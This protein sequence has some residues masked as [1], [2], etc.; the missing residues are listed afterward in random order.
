MMRWREPSG[1]LLSSG[2]SPDPAPTSP[3][4]IPAATA[5]LIAG[6]GPVGS[7]LAV[8]L[9]LRGID[10]LVVE[11]RT[12]I[13]QRV[14]A[15]ELSAPTMEQ[16]ARWGVAEP[17]RGRTQGHSHGS[18]WFRGSLAEP[19]LGEVSWNAPDPAQVAEPPHVAAQ[20]HVNALLRERALE[21]GV[22]HVLGW[23]LEE[24]RQDDEGVEVELRAADG[25]ATA[26]VSA[27][28]VV[29]ADGG[30]S[31][32]RATAGIP[33]TET[34]L[35]ARHY[36]LVVRLPDLVERLGAM[37]DLVDMVWTPDWH[38]LAHV[39][40]AQAGV[41][42]QLIGPFP[43]DY[44]LSDAEAVELTRRFVGADVEVEV[45]QKPS[46]PIQQRIADRYHAGRV[47]LAGDAGHLFPPYMGQNMNTGIG[48][49]TNLGWKLAALL[50]G[51]GGPDLLPSYTAER[52][53]VAQRTADSSL[54][55]WRT[56]LQVQEHV[57]D[58]GLPG[59]GATQEERR[60]VAERMNAISYIEWNK[61][62][63]VLDV[64]YTGSPII[65]DD[66]QPA[67]PWEHTIYR[68]LAKPGHRLPHARLA[69]GTSL[70]ALLGPDFTLLDLG[71]G[72]A[73]ASAA[74]HDA[75]GRGIPLVTVVAPE[76]RPHYKADLVLVRPDRHVAWRG[77]R[78]PEMVWDVV[79]GASGTME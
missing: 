47:A 43:P 19:A 61:D 45:L 14:K 36:N 9:A 77:G 37:P 18:I 62:G 38:S 41:W 56:T 69:D 78:V 10:C 73:A 55:A 35:L 34:E 44:E 4:D 59:G 64:R 28:Y 1:W 57:R 7:A 52:R 68:P 67:P 76:L 17:L 58:E 27:A 72:D 42:R 30:R 39:V 32:T 23:A 70:Y 26:R 49:A 60:R 21:L 66:K 29:G 11:R 22:P 51:W 15:Q 25:D 40:D 31:R 3:D 16:F 8:D 46:F 5:V 75:R 50:Q 53:A 20:R 33:R 13:D 2:M 63:V 71:A 54:A 48:D 65:V 79:R 12:T 74:A 6:G 24:L